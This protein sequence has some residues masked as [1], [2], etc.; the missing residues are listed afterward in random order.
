MFSSRLETTQGNSSTFRWIVPVLLPPHTA[1]PPVVMLMMLSTLRLAYTLNHKLIL[2]TFH[3]LCTQLLIS[4]RRSS[5]AA[6]TLL[7][8]YHSQRKSVFSAEYYKKSFITTVC[9]R[10]RVTFATFKPILSHFGLSF[11]FIFKH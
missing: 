2:K 1:A 10:L 6:D 8:E 4:L 9:F 11:Y 5:N 7:D 3:C